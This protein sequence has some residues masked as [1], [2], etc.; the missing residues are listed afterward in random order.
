MTGELVVPPAR[1]AGSAVRWSPR[2]RRLGR[3]V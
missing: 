2:Q 1:P 3:S